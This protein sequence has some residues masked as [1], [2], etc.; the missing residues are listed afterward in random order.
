MSKEVLIVS[1]CDGEHEHRTEASHEHTLTLDGEQPVEL[2]LCDGHEQLMESVRAL[3]DRGTPVKRGAKPK[4]AKTMASRPGPKPSNEYLSCPEPGC[5]GGGKGRVGLAQ[6]VM[7]VHGK[8]LADY[9][10]TEGGAA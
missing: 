1:Y 3:V 2:D 8:G 4:P 5:T 10:T 9:D 7:R 6:H